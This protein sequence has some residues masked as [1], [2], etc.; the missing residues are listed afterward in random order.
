M[1]EIF[2]KEIELS[3]NLNSQAE[4]FQ[5]FTSILRS[6]LQAAMICSSEIAMRMTSMSEDDPRVNDFAQRFH[7][8]SD[9]LPIEALDVLIPIIRSNVSKKYMTGWF[10]KSADFPDLEP[11]A[12][13]LIKWVEF[14]NKRSAHGVVDLRDIETWCETLESLARD[15]LSVFSPFL[16]KVEVDDTL[17]VEVGDTQITLETPLVFNKSA[18]VINKVVCRKSIWKMQC[19]YLS[20]SNAADLTLDLGQKNIFSSGHASDEKFRLSEI[21]F[22]ATKKS[23][24]NNIPVRQTNTFV[25]RTKEIAK[26][27]KWMK[28]IDD[29]R[30]CL[31]YGDGG[32]GKTTL[33]LEFFNRLLDGSLEDLEHL[34]TLISYYTA[35]KT[36]WTED[37]LTHFKGISDAVE[38]SVRE[39]LYFIYPVLGK[40]WYKVQGEAL[41]DKIVGEFST[42]GLNRNDILLILDNTETLAT[43][44]KQVEELSEFL[45]LVGKKIGRVLITSRRREF[46]PA[47]PVPVDALAEDEAASLM[48]RLGEEYGARSITQAG[49][50]RRRSACRQLSCKPLLID[51]LVKYIARSSTGIQDGLDQILKKTSDELL[52]FLYEDA[53]LRINELARE[54]FLV[55][56]NIANPIDGDCIG[57]ACRE[58]GIQHTEFQS[59]LDE[60]YFATITDRGEDYD[61]E[62]VDLAREFFRKK[63]NKYNSNDIDR[64]TGIAS[65]VDRLASDRHSAEEQYKQDRVADAFRSSFAKA[66]KVA[67][68]KRDYPAARENFELAILDE[69]M[70]ASLRERYASFLLRDMQ[71][72]LDA[73]PVA[74]KAVELDSKN[75]DASFTLALIL[76]RLNDIKEGDKAIDNALINGKHKALCALRQA[77]ARYHYARRTPYAKDTS[78]YLNEAEFLLES[79]LKHSDTRDMYYR[80]NQEEAFKYIRLVQALRASISR[81]DF[82]SEGAAGSVS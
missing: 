79:F 55:I 60:T 2:S 40:E 67:A 25:G 10:E 37:G 61:L 72:P 4:R 59:S 11:L 32:F 71:L 44:A 15:C 27:Q 56:A 47:T 30:Y 8:P 57:D 51:T 41:V 73:K 66:A 68:L 6:I 45:M 62:V 75:G 22:I 29:S 17:L 26:L 77:I 78:R 14:R 76:Y 74:E 21:D 33:A 54:V 9:G 13:K 39:L 5:H 24:I 58:I 69:P 34:P 18:L 53:W 20:W 82:T 43:S 23:I 31:I 3:H 52:E 28:D 49:E 36:K 42:L 38:D 81:R 63:L 64:I 7:Q 35:K 48:L 1:K 70:N 65:K 80:K 16:P 12:P 50:A 19:Q 46:L